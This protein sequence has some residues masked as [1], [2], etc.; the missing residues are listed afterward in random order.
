MHARTAFQNSNIDLILFGIPETEYEPHVT[1]ASSEFT[2]IICD[3]SQLGESGTEVSK[4]VVGFTSEGEAPNGNV[5]LLQAEEE[6]EGS[7]S[8]KEK[9]KVKEEENDDVEM[10]DGDEEGGKR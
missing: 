8:E 3:L 6:A 5:L 10:V 2:R 1:M 7:T 9:T 4:E